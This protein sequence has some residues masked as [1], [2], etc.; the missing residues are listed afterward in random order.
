MKLVK[1]IPAP[2]VILALLAALAGCGGSGSST[3]TT[4]STSTGAATAQK[5]GKQKNQKTAKGGGSQQGKTNGTAT[6]DPNPLPNQGAKAVAPGVPTAKHGNAIQTYG[7]EGPVTER[8][9]ATRFIASYL[10]TVAAGDW[11]AACDY[12]PA[13]IRHKAASAAKRYPQI[14]GSG[15]GAGLG[16]FLGTPP[17]ALLRASTRVHVLSFRVKG[18]RAFLIYRNSAGK[19]YY[20][21][22]NRHGGGWQVSSLTGVGSVL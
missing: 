22:L 7:T 19:F 8:V 2:I 14:K 20:L 13:A 10:G 18:D 3:S 1:T 21:S 11:A 5:G 12:L 17:K 15:C 9:Q 4:A 6:T 16:A